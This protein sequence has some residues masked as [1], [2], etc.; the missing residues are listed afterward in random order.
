[1]QAGAAG[2]GFD[3][4]DKGEAELRAFE[5]PVRLSEVRGQEG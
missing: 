3:F 4:T 1:M 5:R 2:N